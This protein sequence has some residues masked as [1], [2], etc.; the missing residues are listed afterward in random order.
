[1]DVADQGQVVDLGLGAAVA[2]GRHRHLELAGQVGELLGPSHA[3]LDGQQVRGGVE[4]L[5]GVD[6]GHR[7]AEH[8]ADGVPAGLQAAQP[9]PVELVKDGGDVGDHDPVELDVLAVGDVGQVAAVG[10][11]QAADGLQLVGRQ[12]APGDADAQHEMAV[13]GRALGVQAPPAEADVEVVGVDRGQALAGVAVDAGAQVE[14]V[15]RLL[16]LLVAVASVLSSHCWSPR[17]GC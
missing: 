8:V 6:P 15:Q 11:G 5:A 10:L 2:A 9:D 17:C 14:R 3:G 1:V 7:A 13:L 12:R 4:P 16:D